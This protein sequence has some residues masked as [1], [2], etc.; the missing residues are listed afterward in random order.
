MTRVRIAWG[1]VIYAAVLLGVDLWLYTRAPQGISLMRQLLMG[2][3]ALAVGAIALVVAAIL[4][5][6]RRLPVIAAAAVWTAV[7]VWAVASGR[8]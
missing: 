1:L 2:R 8:G 7:A 5:R 4:A 3:A 6:G